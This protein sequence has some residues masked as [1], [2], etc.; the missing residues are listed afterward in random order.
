MKT[1][2]IIGIVLTLNIQFNNPNKFRINKSN[3]L[4][5]KKSI[6]KVNNFQMF[7]YKI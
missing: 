2:N 1:N 5:K 4:I 6:T 3:K 7:F